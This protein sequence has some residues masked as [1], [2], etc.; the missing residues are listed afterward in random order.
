[1]SG[2]G[3]QYKNTKNAPNAAEYD[4]LRALPA[5]E[6]RRRFAK[7]EADFLSGLQ[8]F[9]NDKAQKLVLNH[10]EIDIIGYKKR[11]RKTI[12]TY[13]A[14]PIKSVKILGW[15]YHKAYGDSALRYQVFKKNEYNWSEWRWLNGA[16][17][18]AKIVI[19][20]P[21]Q[22]SKI[23]GFLQFISIGFDHVMP[24]GWDHILFII[25]MALSSIL[26]RHLLLLVSSFTLAH[27][28]TLGLA[29]LGVVEVSARIV[30]PLI[31]FSIAYVAF[32]NLLPKQSIRR[33]SLVVFLFGLVHGLG[34]AS[35]LKTFQ[36]PPNSFLSTLIGFNIGVELAQIVII[37]AVLMLLFLLHIL[38][39]NQR[40]LPHAP[41]EIIALSVGFIDFHRARPIS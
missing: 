31:A 36:M 39:L 37:F 18:N 34:F 38:G 16:N 13:S 35:M 24:L 23:K 20:N 17:P 6:L 12:L 8:L 7:F 25:G 40:K 1:M 9:I 2:I 14:E 3:T 10:A 29:M 5:A 19:D 41:G 4:E 33:K 28:L 11:P 15:Q 30:E 22:T 21:P 27:T 26:W 32:E